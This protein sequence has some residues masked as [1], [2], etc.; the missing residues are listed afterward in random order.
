MTTH[1]IACP[2][3]RPAPGTSFVRLHR[4]PT[5]IEFADG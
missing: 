5:P 2:L 3:L 1:R 4:P